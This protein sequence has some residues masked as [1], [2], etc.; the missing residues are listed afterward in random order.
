VIARL[1]VAAAALMIVFWLG[2]ME[3]DTRLQ[4][5]AQQAALHGHVEVA[6]S[7][8][9]SARFLNLDTEPDFLRA[10][11]YYGAGDGR[12]ALALINSILAR[13]P[14]NLPAW[15]QLRAMTRKSDPPTA[16]HALAEMRRL[17]PLDVKAR[18]GL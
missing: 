11:L 2:S 10:I 9:R 15:A 6:Q 13:E 1:A 7:R 18:R 5:D 14:D 12:R 16:A 8:L 4:S 17:D 3:R